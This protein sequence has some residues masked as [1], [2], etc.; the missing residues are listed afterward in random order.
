MTTSEYQELK[1]VCETYNEIINH[2]EL[3]DTYW[4]EDMKT[5]RTVQ[6]NP[7]LIEMNEYFQA[8]K[9][10]FP[11][12]TGY[13]Y[14]FMEIY[15]SSDSQLTKE[16][17][18]LGKRA[19]RFGLKQGDLSNRD[20]RQKLYEYLM[21]YQPRDVWMSPSCKAWCRWN[22]FNASKSPEAARKVMNARDHETIHMLL[23]NA[24]CQHQINHH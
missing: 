14:D 7:V 17:T 18:R 8:N 13:K 20:G 21:R 16:I 10:R 24:V 22:Q 2:P 15:C 12:N 11:Q 19:I 1:H 6:D 5:D 3:F 9:H 4:S 23:C